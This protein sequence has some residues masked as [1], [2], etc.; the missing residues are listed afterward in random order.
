MWRFTK[1]NS[2]GISSL[3]KENDLE[4]YVE[5]KSLITITVI[6]VIAVLNIACFLTKTVSCSEK[7]ILSVNTF[8][9]SALIDS[10]QSL[11]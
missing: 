5:N 11:E 3:T 1:N 6:K 4:G 2:E 9:H 8:R 7:L 10:H